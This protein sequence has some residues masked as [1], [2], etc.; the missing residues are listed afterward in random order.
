MTQ[1]REGLVRCCQ[2]SRWRRAE[3]LKAARVLRCLRQGWA[4][5]SWP[6]QHFPVRPEPAQ[7]R[8][9]AYA[10]LSSAVLLSP[11]ALPAVAFGT[12]GGTQSKRYAATHYIFVAYESYSFAKPHNASQTRYQ[13]IRWLS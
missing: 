9:K 1:V 7:P 11:A 5:Y 2:V 8:Q 6:A 3:L 10:L 12:A 13:M 4:R